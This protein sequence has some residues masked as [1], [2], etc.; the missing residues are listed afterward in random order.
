MCCCGIK[1]VCV[2]VCIHTWC[3]CVYTLVHVVV[4]NTLMIAACFFSCLCTYI[5]TCI[6]AH[7]PTHIL[8]HQS[9]RHVT[10]LRVKS[11]LSNS[12][13]TLLLPRNTFTHSVLATQYIHSMCFDCASPTHTHTHKQTNKH[14]HTQTKTYTHTHTLTNT[15]THIH[16]AGHTYNS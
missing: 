9:M 10:W 12:T 8:I 15:H 3:M 16:T 13:L 11:G 14:T 5:H 7:M 4:C 2:Y 1:C 6:H